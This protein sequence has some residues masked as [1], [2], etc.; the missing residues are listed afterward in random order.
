[1]TY[2]M[3]FEQEAMWLQEQ[4]TEGDSVLLEAWVHRLRG[5]LDVAA[6]EWALTEVVRRQPTLR[7]R[8]VFDDDA[9]VQAVD[10]EPGPVLARR[11][12]RPGE[13][14]AELRTVVRTRLDLAEPPFRATLFEL[15]ADDFVLAIEFHHT[16][17]DDWSYLVLNRELTELYRARVEGRAPDLPPLTGHLG[18]FAV[19]QRAAGLDP[20]VLDWWRATLA[21][22]SE[23]DLLPLDRPRPE[24][25]RQ[26]GEQ[27][28]F[29]VP[30]GLTA[31]VRRVARAARSTPFTV[32][33][34]A[35]FATLHGYTGESD[36]LI[37]VPVSRRG[38]AALDPLIGCLTDQM[39]V[40][41]RLRPESSFLDLVA[42]A[43]RALTAAMAHR[44]V[45]YAA[46]LRTIG[47]NAYDGKPPLVQF[48]LVI[49]DAPRVPV[50]LPGIGATRLFVDPGTS[51]FDMALYLIRTGGDALHGIL[52]Y[53]DEL[54]DRS[55]A[56]GV[57]ADFAGLLGA[58]VA[59]PDTAVASLAGRRAGR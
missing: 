13:L 56:A 33:A 50:D 49:D 35:L 7:T 26:T 20:A 8:L 32:Y 38:P 46:L 12:C 41:L 23:R 57:A 54:F 40:R 9:L 53:A 51:K 11:S 14:D 28:G 36:L 24:Q 6:L 21:G 4:A 2:P 3:T 29:A 52:E 47:R 39:P 42:A 17:V 25:P 45:P 37:G 10:D 5:P 30:A 18:D 16:A 1:M 15:A 31:G 27:L 44:D 22:V 34:A 43:K 19:R 48:S 55:T 59:A 58:A